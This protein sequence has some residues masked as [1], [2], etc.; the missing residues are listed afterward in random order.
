MIESATSIAG[1]VQFE[2]KCEKS[3]ETEIILTMIDSIFYCFIPFLITLLFSFLTLTK[4]F[5]IKKSQRLIKKKHIQTNLNWKPKLT[6]FNSPLIDV[7]LD[8]LNYKDEVERLAIKRIS[9]LKKSS[10]LDH[11]EPEFMVVRYLRKRSSLPDQFIF[12]A[13]NT[14]LIPHCEFGDDH[15][16]CSRKTDTFRITFML[17]IFPLSFILTTF[18]IFII[19]ALRTLNFDFKLNLEIAFTIAK[20]SMYLN[21]SI[22][23]LFLI[24][25]G[26]KHRKDFLNIFCP[27]R[28][29]DFNR[30]MQTHSL[31]SNNPRQFLLIS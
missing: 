31:R 21:N 3:S 23:V 4:L 5:K 7:N 30:E 29:K 20:L 14:N 28:F 25:F 1:V 26:K 22:N 10:S 27:S 8:K 2:T 12:K 19:I 18:P 24:I 15:L 11:V 17:M 6:T 16:R 13:K 9:N